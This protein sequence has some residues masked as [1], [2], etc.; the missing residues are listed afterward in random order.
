[1]FLHTFSKSWLK[2]TKREVVNLSH[3]GHTGMFRE[4]WHAGRKRRQRNRKSMIRHKE[5]KM[6]DQGRKFKIQGGAGEEVALF[7]AAT[8]DKQ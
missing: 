8:I 3:C 4:G 6:V 2:V 7:N 5:L 1:M